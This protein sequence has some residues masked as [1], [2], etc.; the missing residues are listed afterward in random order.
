MDAAP[1]RLFDLRRRRRARAR[2]AAAFSEHDFLHRR[3]LLD[4][5][6]RLQSI[7]RPFPQ[8]MLYG[9]ASLSP[10]LAGKAGADALLLADPSS[11]RL[12]GRAGI[13]FEEDANPVREASLDLVVSVL[14]LHAANDP[15]GALAQWRRALR[16]DGLF[17]GAVFGEE[18][19]ASWRAALYAAETQ[20]KGG[21]A[22]RVHPF[23][24]VQ[25]WGAALQRA[26]FAMPV[27]DVDSVEVRYFSAP[28]LLSDLKGMGETGA[29][30]RPGPPATRGL[31]ALALDHFA[32]SGGVARFDVVFLTGWAPAPSQ[33]RP[34]KPGSAQRSLAEAVRKAAPGTD[35]SA[36]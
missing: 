14:T 1:P 16:P 34:L 19:L 33:P 24:S 13:A 20:L 10:M 21:V 31:L 11:S 2:G 15:V 8:A 6:D 9:A 26:G 17:I 3:A 28:R 12:S 22:A 5:A 35:E 27:V 36:V 25:A 18:T 29:L 32:Q 4:V 23:A 7:T 30:A